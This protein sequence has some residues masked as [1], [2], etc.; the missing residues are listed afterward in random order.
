MNTLSKKLAIDIAILPPEDV[1]EKLIN[2]NRQAA[3]KNL[4]WGPLAKDD[5]LPH[6]SL[7][8]G[9]IERNSLETVRDIV[10][11]IAKKFNPIPI[12]LNELYYVEKP[13]GSRTYAIRAKNTPVLQ[14][15]HENL[16]NG[17]GQ[18]F[19]YDCTKET[20]YSKPGEEVTDPSYLNKF[21]TSSFKAFDPHITTRT[22]KNVG[23]EYLPLKF[24]ATQV[25]AC[26]AGIKTT[27]RKVLFAVE[28]RD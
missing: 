5:F 3:A 25:V 14:K 22:K 26:H 6:M 24:I 21:S 10:K 28:F 8:M 16:M 15:F 9:G 19:S 17:L 1:M 20:I 12:E 2:I 13:D 18:Y 11:K 4:T 7:A 23:Q 27:C